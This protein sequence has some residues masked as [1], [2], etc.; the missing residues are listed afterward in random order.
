MNKSSFHDACL[1]H[2]TVSRNLA[3]I[4]IREISQLA[5]EWIPGD[6]N[7]VADSISRDTDLSNADL[8]VLRLH[9]PLQL[10]P[11][12]EIKV[13]PTESAHG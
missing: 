9:V 2:F 10:L 1:V 7:K 12:F 11:N 4:L 13:L 5:S 8:T 6:T 3:K